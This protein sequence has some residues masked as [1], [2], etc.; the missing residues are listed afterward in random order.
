MVVVVVVLLTV[1]VLS[2]RG[3]S[4]NGG[5]WGEREVER[6]SGMKTWREGGCREREEI[7]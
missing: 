5:D 3:W 1:M 2:W 6:V 4:S 7:H